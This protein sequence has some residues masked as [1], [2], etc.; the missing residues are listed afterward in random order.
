VTGFSGR[1]SESRDL[2]GDI[3]SDVAIAEAS[4][5]PLEEAPPDRVQRSR[6]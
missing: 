1:A 3:A 6:E 2:F 5:I 4:V